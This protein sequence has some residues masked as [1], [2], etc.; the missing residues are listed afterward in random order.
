M[1]HVF[2]TVELLVLESRV[3]YPHQIVQ[4]NT[5]FH[6]DFDSGGVMLHG[7]RQNLEA[8]NQDSD[9]GIFN[10]PPGAGK[11]VVK[12]TLFIVQTPTAVWLHHGLPDG[13]GIVA[14]EEVGY[15]L[16]VIRQRI[17]GRESDCF[18]FCQFLVFRVYCRSVRS[19]CSSRLQ[20]P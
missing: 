20:W 9:L 14:G 13:E 1:V 5:S 17:W 7:S 10:H 12:C 16:V 11:P 3:P 6:D 18:V 15:I 19:L 2:F 4:D 8:V